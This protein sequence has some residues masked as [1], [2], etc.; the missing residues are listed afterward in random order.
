MQLLCNK[1]NI[2]SNILD[3]LQ[4]CT[5]QNLKKVEMTDFY[6]AGSAKIPPLLKSRTTKKKSWY[7]FPQTFSC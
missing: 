7:S 6:C 2:V 4:N 3:A 5:V 1:V